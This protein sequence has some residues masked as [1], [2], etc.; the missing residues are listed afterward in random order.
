MNLAETLQSRKVRNKTE[1]WGEMNDIST[2]FCS[3]TKGSSDCE[4]EGKEKS[5]SI[6]ATAL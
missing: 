4:F 2:L 5:S 6:C 3:E 1:T